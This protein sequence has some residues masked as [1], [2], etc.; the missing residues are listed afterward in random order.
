MSSER[1]VRVWRPAPGQLDERDEAPSEIVVEF[2]RD[3]DAVR[4]AELEAANSSRQSLP[5]PAFTPD[6]FR[7][8]PVKGSLR[9]GL[10]K[11]RHVLGD[12]L[13]VAFDKAQEAV[14]PDRA[15]G[16]ATE[17]AIELAAKRSALGD[18]KRWQPGDPLRLLLVG[19]SGTRNTGADVRVEEMIRQLRHLFGDDHLALSITTIDPELTRGYFRA[20]RQI[21]SP[22]I[23][24]RFLYDVIDEQHGVVTCEG[25]MFKSKFADAL[26]TYMVGALGVAAAEGK[27][28]IC[29][30]GEAGAMSRGLE[31]LVRKHVRD[32]FVVTRNSE[33]ADILGRLG[34][35]TRVGTDTAWTFDPAAPEVGRQILVDAGWDG[36]TPVLA[37]CP[38]NPFWWPVK[39]DVPKAAMHALGGLDDEAHFG[40]VYFH[41]DAPEVDTK[42][43]RY[44]DAWAGAVERFRRDHDVFPVLFG[45]EQ[46]DRIACEALNE[47]LGGDLPVIVSDEHD[48]YQ[49][50]AAMRQA[51]FMVS[52]RY[53]ACVMSM[54]AGVVSI[55]VTMD[56]R[57]RNLMRDRGTPELALEVDDPQLESSLL[58]ALERASNDEDRLRDGIEGSVVRNLELM[59]KMGAILVDHVRSELPDFPLRPEL[60]EQ[61]DPWDHLPSLSPLL[62]GLVRKHRHP[63]ALE[64]KP[65]ARR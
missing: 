61:G 38:I 9:G 49:M 62:Q 41:N 59:G 43:A 26:S 18:S 52:S 12:A 57:I 4:R 24:P 44:L 6:D 3:T 58:A 15:L 51:R 40:S 63:H 37:L 10:R 14:D 56:E 20:V 39:P 8:G 60:G 36:E 16:F 25:S 47:R 53:H 31:S 65:G 54:A 48:M 21:Y 30:G 7:R 45:S 1:K 42:Q 11:L 33:S 19:Y 55:G 27:L 46:L 13:E 5:P 50:V 2:E 23:F 22:K 34:V 35:A 64:S 17:M 29:Y 32:S 28:S